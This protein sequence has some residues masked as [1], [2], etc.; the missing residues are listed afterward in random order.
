MKV[1]KEFKKEVDEEMEETW[2]VFKKIALRLALIIL[3]LTIGFG[4]FGIF[5]TKTINKAQ[6][7][8]KREVFKQ[9]NTYVESSTNFLAKEYNEYSKAKTQEDRNAICQY[10][11]MRYPNL[12]I[13]SIENQE[14]K[15]FYIKCLNY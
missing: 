1:N 11:I 3:V 4:L 8:A 7:N 6:T 13:D 12:D 14:L 9:T 10:V 15:N 2:Y 5:Y